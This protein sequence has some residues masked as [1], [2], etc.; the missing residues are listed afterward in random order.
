M[1]TVL[2]W[3]NAAIWAA[4]PRPIWFVMPAAC[5]AEWNRHVAQPLEAMLTL[6]ELPQSSPA[7]AFVVLRNRSVTP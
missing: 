2:E 5:A 4:K 7:R 1:T 3:E 6:D